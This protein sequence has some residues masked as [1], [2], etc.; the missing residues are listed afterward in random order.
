MKKYL[1]KKTVYEGKRFNVEQ[2][3]YAD[4]QGKKFLFD[5]VITK[6]AVT[7][8]PITKEGKIV[9]V[10]E[11]RTAIGDIT[12]YDLPAG[13]IED[14]ES[15]ELAA[16]RELPEETGYVTD[17]LKFLCDYY[18]SKGYTN[19]KIY[20][21]LAENLENKG[22]Q[23]LDDAEEIDTYEFEYDEVMEM[24]NNGE[25]NSAPLY[26]SLLMYKN[27]KEKNN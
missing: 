6:S 16:L 27:I 12:S 9:F 7:I 14:G 3:T 13:V 25:F 2:V 1:N 18:A 15:P 24:L 21:F 23:N 17:K 20:I 11:T 22:N 8:L 19:E 26:I 10:K 4:E 5:H